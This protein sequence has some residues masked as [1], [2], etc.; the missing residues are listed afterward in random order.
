MFIIQV[1][2]VQVKISNMVGIVYTLCGKFYH[3]D[4]YHPT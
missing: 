4:F 3:W 2:T 1:Y